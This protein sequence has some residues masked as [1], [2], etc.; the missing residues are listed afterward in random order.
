MRGGPPLTFTFS[1][2]EREREREMED[3]GE[4]KKVSF[5]VDLS[6]N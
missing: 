3:N 6:R 1:T 4:V 2:R 5:V